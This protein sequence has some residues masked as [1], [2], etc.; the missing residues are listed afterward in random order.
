MN[1]P[2]VVVTGANGLVG[3]RVCAALTERGAR[4]RAIVRRPGTAP[5]GTDEVVGD[6]HDPDIAA[7]ACEGATAVVNTV[8]PM[9]DDQEHLQATAVGWAATLA[10][11][12]RDAGVERF[13][14]TSTT[15]VY[16]RESDTG[17][18]DEDSPLV[19]DDANAYAVTKRDT[20]AA[21]AEVD[22]LTRVIVRP[23]AI[24]GAGETSVWNTLR[25]AQIGGDDVAGRTDDPTR[26]F[27]WVH[28]DDLAAL[29]ADLATGR[30][31][32]AD[33]PGR[34]PVEGELT[35][36]NAV[37]G[38]VRIRDYL[39]PIAEALGVEP[40]WEQRGG[41]TQKLL[42]ERARTWGWQPRVT[43]QQAMDELLAGLPR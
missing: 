43:F 42:A 37:S 11:A 32:L 41:F 16:R 7:R 24:L 28:V 21:L 9:S 27:G 8:H 40:V 5:G 13:V 10:S 2:L 6:F 20:D 39:E 4:V 34:G 3:S 30:I 14:H 23:T 17:D 31:A 19:D 15:G 38:N 26:T 36:A 1:S 18:V 35:I 25:P 22:G 29:L 12:A 33:D